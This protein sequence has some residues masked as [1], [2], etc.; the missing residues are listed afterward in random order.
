MAAPRLLVAIVATLVI[1][2]A[3]GGATAQE[4]LILTVGIPNDIGS[5]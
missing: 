4:R 5:L 2:T 1:L 3:A